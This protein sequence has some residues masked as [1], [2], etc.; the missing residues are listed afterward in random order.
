MQYKVCHC[1]HHQVRWC[2]LDSAKHE[3]QPTSSNC[4]PPAVSRSPK[5]RER[6]DS[7]SHWIALARCTPSPATFPLCRRSTIPQHRGQPTTRPLRLLWPDLNPKNGCQG[8]WH[9]NHRPLITI[10]CYSLDHV[11]TPIHC[12]SSPP[13]IPP[14][15]LAVDPLR[16]MHDC[17][18]FHTSFQCAH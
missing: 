7:A 9:G 10:P 11:V 3:H 18:H 8:T 1:T 17:M 14:W 12:I 5:R 6:R 2:A 13:C 15:A 16:W 4:I